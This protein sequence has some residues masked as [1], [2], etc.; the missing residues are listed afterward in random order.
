[1]N[2]NLYNF[3]IEKIMELS[4]KTPL[5]QYSMLIFLNQ[6]ILWDIEKYKNTKLYS[7]IADKPFA[8]REKRVYIGVGRKKTTVESVEPYLRRVDYLS[9]VPSLLYFYSDLTPELHQPQ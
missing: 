9:C 5:Y 6:G 2:E 7:N 8:R 4:R 3:Y 1:M